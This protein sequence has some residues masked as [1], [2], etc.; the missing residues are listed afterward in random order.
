MHAGQCSAV[1][2]FSPDPGPCS[3]HQRPQPHAHTCD[4]GLDRLVMRSQSVEA[5]LSTAAR[6]AGLQHLHQNKEEKNLANARR[7][8]CFVCLML[9]TSLMTHTVDV[10][11]DGCHTLSRSSVRDA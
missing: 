4:A 2:P 7:G 5:T 8:G 1:Q 11:N 10:N 9:A 6:E 3:L